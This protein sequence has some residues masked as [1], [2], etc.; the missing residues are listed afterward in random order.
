MKFF[1]IGRGSIFPGLMTDGR[2]TWFFLFESATTKI[3]C[4]NIEYMKKKFF[5]WNILWWFVY[6][7]R[8][9]HSFS[10]ENFSSRVC[11]CF[12]HSFGANNVSR[13]SCVLTLCIFSQLKR[14]TTHCLWRAMSILFTLLDAAAWWWFRWCKLKEN[15]PFRLSFSTSRKKNCKNCFRRLLNWGVMK[16]AEMF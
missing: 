7:T 2:M 8:S 10:V 9:F 16:S 3:I 4:N 6:T 13:K 12:F 14:Y 15:F 5:I 1:S 11:V